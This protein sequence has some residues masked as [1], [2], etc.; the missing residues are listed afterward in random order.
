MIDYRI[1]DLDTYKRKDILKHF[2]SYDSP[3]T[4]FTVDIDVTALIEFC[5]KEHCSFFLTFLHILALSADSIPQFRYRLHRLTPE[6]KMDPKHS[7]CTD[8]GPFKDL[9]VREYSKCLTS[10]TE[11]QDDEVYCY[12]F[13]DHYMPWKEYIE[14]AAAIQQKARKDPSL[15]NNREAIEVYYFLSCVPWVHY[16][17]CIHPWGDR[18][19]SNP[20]IG[21]GKYEADFRGRMM[22]PLT[23]NVHHGLVDGQHMAKFYKAVEE[24][25]EKLIAGIDPFDD[26][27]T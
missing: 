14:T 16:T 15:T 18:F 2:L 27:N 20:R 23:V 10:H 1:V 9:E 19:D 25:I 11:S 13:L 5:K 8:K 21:W 26:R 7:K 6:E 24:N 12:C 3:K 22:M 4:G 17:N